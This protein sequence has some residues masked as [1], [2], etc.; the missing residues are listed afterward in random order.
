MG[1]HGK[2][3]PKQDPHVAF[4]CHPKA[5]TILKNLGVNVVTLANNH[6][7]DYGENTLIETL[8]YLDE[9]NIFH[10]GAGANYEEANEP[11][12]F[13]IRGQK[14]AILS[15]V[16]I[17]SA[18]TDRATNT[19][20]GVADYNIKKL[21]KRVF[22][23]K[24][25]GCIVIV[26]IHWGIEYNFYPIPFQSEYAEDLINAG[27]SL[28][29]GHGPHYPQ[30]IRP[31]NNGEIVFSLGNF[32]FDEPQLYSNISFIYGCDIDSEGVVNHSKIY[33]FHIKQHIP[34]LD[35]IE[36][37]SKTV[38]LIRNFNLIYAKKTSN[39]WNRISDRWFS[40]IIWRITTMKSLKFIKLS[41][42][43]FYLLIFQTSLLKKITW[44]NFKVALKI[45]F[46]RLLKSS[47][48]QTR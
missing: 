30:G 5:L 43:K 18:S 24:R 22:N 1:L 39:F 48:D 41:P 21:I 15:S 11:I 14:I 36:E 9:A 29:A 20:A 16:L 47:N 10:L 19:K 33:P 35:E 32:I 6:L 2:P 46:A 4:C 13:T 34:V 38:R 12:L 7:L 25:S 31:Y 8:K 40:D 37:Q 42:F 45:I 26:T 17:Y 27:A 44:R 3:H 28:I 23:L